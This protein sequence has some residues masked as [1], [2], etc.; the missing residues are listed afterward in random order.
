MSNT[1]SAAIASINGGA[2]GPVSASTRPAAFETACRD[3]VAYGA[4]NASPGVMT[5]I[6]SSEVNPETPV[7]EV[8]APEP[9]PCPAVLPVEVPV[10]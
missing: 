6:P 10:V 7:C 4:S 9:L 5:P 2:R 1:A 3:R 8:F